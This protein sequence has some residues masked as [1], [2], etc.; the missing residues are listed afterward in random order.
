MPTT[1]ADDIL[2]LPSEFSDT[3]FILDAHE[4]RREKGERG[5]RR[6]IYRKP[7]RHLRKMGGKAVGAQRA[8]AE[9]KTG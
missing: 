7:R 6:T 2:M 4:Y 8:E 1:N 5:K 3:P 9:G